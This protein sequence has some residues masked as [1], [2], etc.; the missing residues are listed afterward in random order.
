MDTTSL[1][2]VLESLVASSH[3]HPL[4]P[5]FEPVV[6]THDVAKRERLGLFDARHGEGFPPEQ[7]K[8]IAEL[9][10]RRRDSAPLRIAQAR[11]QV[12]RFLARLDEQA[13]LDLAK[14]VEPSTIPERVD[15]SLA[16]ISGR[17]ESMLPRRHRVGGGQRLSV[18]EEGG[19]VLIAWDDV[20]ELG[21]CDL[22]ELATGCFRFMGE[23]EESGAKRLAGEFVR[24]LSEGA[25]FLPGFIAERADGTGPVRYRRIPAVARPGPDRANLADRVAALFDASPT[26]GNQPSIGADVPGLVA[27]LEREYGVS[28]HDVKFA[29]FN[30]MGERVRSLAPDDVSVARFASRARDLDPGS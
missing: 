9:A 18:R 5:A 25:E 28:E 17:I 6:D 3:L 20:P 29:L 26:P 19:R 7:A 4:E 24:A 14:E 13:R 8:R 21:P 12:E 16:G 1:R 22:L 23:L 27:D 2:M 15:R 30:M 11:A 10:R